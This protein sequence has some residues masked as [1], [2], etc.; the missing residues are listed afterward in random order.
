[1][2]AEAPELESQT[3][4]DNAIKTWD[5]TNSGESEV[6]DVIWFMSEGA[7]KGITAHLKLEDTRALPLREIP[8]IPIKNATT[9]LGQIVFGT[10]PS[11]RRVACILSTHLEGHH[12]SETFFIV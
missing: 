9:T 5:M 4:I 6:D 11:G 1:M 3:W 10:A 7:G 2:K 12:S 8:G